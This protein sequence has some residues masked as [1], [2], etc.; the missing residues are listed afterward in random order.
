MLTTCAE[1]RFKTL[2]PSTVYVVGE[3]KYEALSLIY[4]HS[5]R[6]FFIVNLLI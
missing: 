1:F 4:H 6:F 5:V 2:S 3:G